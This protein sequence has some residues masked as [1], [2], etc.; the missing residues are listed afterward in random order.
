MMT[1]ISD[2]FFFVVCTVILLI[3]FILLF[4]YDIALRDANRNGKI[5]YQKPHTVNWP[6]SKDTV[7]FTSRFADCAHDYLIFV[8]AKVQGEDGKYHKG[9]RCLKCGATAWLNFDIDCGSSEE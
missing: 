4:K 3:F 7:G 6:D 8:H 5:N 1:P 9:V 2:P